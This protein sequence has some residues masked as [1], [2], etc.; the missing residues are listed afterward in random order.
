[1]I[2]E[3][4]LDQWKNDPQVTYGASGA[5]ITKSLF[6]TVEDTNSDYCLSLLQMIA[7]DAK[8]SEY[9]RVFFLLK[10]FSVKIFFS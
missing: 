2:S 10:V 4:T 6:D 9:K 3:K 5:T 1:M 8:D 7:N